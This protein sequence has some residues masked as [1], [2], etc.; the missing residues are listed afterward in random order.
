MFFIKFKKYL[1]FVFILIII[2]YVIYQFKI[3]YLKQEIVLDDFGDKKS[4]V[5]NEDVFVLKGQV[6]D[7]K[8]FSING[9][10]VLLDKEYNF[11]KKLYLSDFQN[12]F[13]LKTISKTDIET[14]RTITI[15]KNKTKKE[16]VDLKEKVS[17]KSEKSKESKEKRT[18]E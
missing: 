1:V 13:V 9:N 6:L 7:S 17:E 15:F 10:P 12:T 18:E 14:Q 11:S 2:F 16:N 5:V 8:F 3:F 4:I